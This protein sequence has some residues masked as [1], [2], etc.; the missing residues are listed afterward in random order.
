[1]IARGRHKVVGG[2]GAYR[3]ASLKIISRTVD[4]ELVDVGG[5]RTR[6]A[7]RRTISPLDVMDLP[8]TIL[9]NPI[10][11]RHIGGLTLVQVAVIAKGRSI[12]AKI[13][14]HGLPEVRR[15]TLIGGDI[16]NELMEISDFDSI[17]YLKG[18]ID[19]CNE[20]LETIEP[21]GDDSEFEDD[22]EELDEDTSWM[23]EVDSDE[24]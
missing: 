24:E 4:F 9:T 6:R 12:G 22:E 19:F 21:I 3:H 10:G 23:D 18:I 15:Q 14:R 7:P 1:M 8:V 20:K 11:E 2:V 13:D 16:E 17:E 5:V